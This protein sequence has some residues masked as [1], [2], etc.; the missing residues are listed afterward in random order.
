MGRVCEIVLGLAGNFKF[1]AG[2]LIEFNYS[3]SLDISKIRWTCPGVQRISHTLNG[4]GLAKERI[5]LHSHNYG[6]ATLTIHTEYLLKFFFP[7]FF[8]L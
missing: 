8:H 7:F 6:D 1:F 3:S 4:E 2:H 5:I